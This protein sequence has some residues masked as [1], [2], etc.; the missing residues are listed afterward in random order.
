MSQGRGQEGL[1]VLEPA[2][3]DAGIADDTRAALFA[4]G[5]TLR[6]VVGDAEGA[7]VLGEE[8]V[9]LSELA[10]EPGDEAL[11]L[12]TLGMVERAAGNPRRAVD[13]AA[14]SA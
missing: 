8:G 4:M 6:V 10:G 14:H 3:R 7:R 11:N 5:T 9:R 13:L 12:A 1:N 2:L